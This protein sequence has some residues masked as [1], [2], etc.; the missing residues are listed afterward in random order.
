[1][2]EIILHHYPTSPYAEKVRLAF[3]LKNLAWRSVLIPMVMPK[4][5]L[6]P[7]TGGY[8]KTPVMQ[9]G[10]HIYCDTLCI[11]RELERRHPAPPLYPDGQSGTAHAIAWWAEKTMFNMAVGAAS[12]DMAGKLPEG[13][14][15]DRS[16]FM[17]AEFNVA[18]MKAVRPILVD[19]L[20]AQL[21]V[22]NRM[23][24]ARDFV[25]GSD[26]GLA[27]LAAY[28]PLWFIADNCGSDAPPLNEFPR[29]M[30]WMARIKA[31]GH[32]RMTAMTSGEALEVA[33]AATP[34]LAPAADPFD[35][36]GRKPGQRVKVRADDVG[37]EPAIG[38]IVMSSADE[39]VISREDDRAGEVFVHFPRAGFIVSPA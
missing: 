5:D 28:H 39:I 13:F 16:A 20:R 23:V 38:E 29:I 22:L 21:S 1:M 2:S 4:P 14:E 37:R 25:L 19:Q 3:G 31:I 11:L 27:D 18:R 36:A 34:S 10:A 6:M 17:G 35:P 9:I 24:A 33:K 30:D 26:P 12:A 7:L 15:Q 8:R 32:G